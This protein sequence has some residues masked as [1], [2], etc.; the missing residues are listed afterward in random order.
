MREGEGGRVPQHNT[1]E[2]KEGGQVMVMG[3]VVVR[4]KVRI[5]DVKMA[6]S[7]PPFNIQ[8]NGRQQP[9]V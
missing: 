3:R 2:V 8:R 4:F 5:K 6:A 1:F 9:T 7:S